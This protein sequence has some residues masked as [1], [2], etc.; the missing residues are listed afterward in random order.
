MRLEKI[1]LLLRGGGGDYAVR[2]QDGTRIPVS[3]SRVDE[4][5]DRLGVDVLQR[6]D[7]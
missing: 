3:R 2:L 1:E 7:T 4:L 5:E 6:D